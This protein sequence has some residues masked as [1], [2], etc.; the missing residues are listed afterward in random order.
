MKPK[1]GKERVD[2]VIAPAPAEV[3][4]RIEIFHFE[5]PYPQA[6]THYPSGEA[7]IGGTP[8]EV[9]VRLAGNHGIWEAG[10]DLRTALKQLMRSCK[11]FGHAFRIE[12]YEVVFADT[13]R[14]DAFDAGGREVPQPHPLSFPACSGAGEDNAGIAGA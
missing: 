8:G 9:K 12:Q 2:A 6:Y 14:C 4:P 3:K 11:I 7:K 5:M 10:K 13:V 1:N